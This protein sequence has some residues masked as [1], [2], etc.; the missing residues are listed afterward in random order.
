MRVEWLE[1]QDF[2]SYQKAAL[3]FDREVTVFSGENA[4]GKTNL[5]E[6]IFLC[7]TARSHR[8]PRDRELIHFGKMCIRDSRS[9]QQ[10]GKGLGRRQDGIRRAEQGIR[11]PYV[12]NP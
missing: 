3:D 5:L 6:A 8:T 12:L 9:S 2:R 7:C 1:L 11:L 4:K 10:P